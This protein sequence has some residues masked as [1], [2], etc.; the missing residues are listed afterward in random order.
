MIKSQKDVSFPV[1][2]E[3]DLSMAQVNPYLN[4]NGNCK[5]AMTFYSQCFGGELTL[6]T[7][8]GSP[9]AEH[10]GP[11]YKNNILHAS[12]TKD[13][14]AVLMASDAMRP[15]YKQGNNFS[16]SVNCMSDDEIKTLFANF[17]KGGTVVQPLTDAFWGATFGMLID[18]FGINWMFNY[19]HKK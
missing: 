17:S 7:V 18:K 8:E 6:Q 15:D 13:G 19:E 3:V 5:E 4:F 16:V 1:L 2:N 9:A 11:E 10:M 14:K 12:I